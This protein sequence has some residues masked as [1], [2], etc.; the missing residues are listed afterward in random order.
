METQYLRDFL[1]VVKCAN[2]SI[3]AGSLFES[4]SVISKHITS[5]EHELGVKLFDR[6]T[7]SVKLTEYGKLFAKYAAQIVESEDSY[8]RDMEALCENADNILRILA[9]P[10]IL[11]YGVAEKLSRFKEEHP[12]IDLKIT[13][14][15]PLN[16]DEHYK[17]G[18]FDMAICGSLVISGNSV[19]CI[20]IFKSNM[21]AVMRADHPLATL[22]SVPLSRL[23]GED[24]LLNDET[25]SLYNSCI[26]EF[27]AANITPSVVY[28]GTRPETILQFVGEGMGIAIMVRRVVEYYNMENIRC[29]DIEPAMNAYLNLEWDEKRP[30]KSAAKLLVQYLRPDV[31]AQ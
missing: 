21:V 28:K 23:G 19:K 7:R 17:E 8:R 5:L 30:M 20:T 26:K 27:S 9:I 14:C 10:V 24:L 11:H 29:V 31:T 6:T 16:L 22:K 1:A 25:T 3:A 4:A 15:Q 12:E 18:I 13:E 2:F